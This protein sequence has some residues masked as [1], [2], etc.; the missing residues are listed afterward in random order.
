MRSA[1]S[2]T[3]LGSAA[4]DSARKA[5][6]R[7]WMIYSLCE[8]LG[9]LWK[10]F[11]SSKAVP[12]FYMS[13]CLSYL[14]AFISFVISS[15][16]LG[17][18]SGWS[19]FLKRCLLRRSILSSSFTSKLLTH[20]W[21]SDLFKRFYLSWFRNVYF[22]I[23]LNLFFAIDHLSFNSSF[24]ST[25]IILICLISVTLFLSSRELFLESWSSF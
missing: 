9:F 13:S 19:L 20:S 8:H 18:I 11:P 17:L 10:T 7:C 2:L 4:L 25:E 12:N 15:L 24:S 3:D 22:F 5:W 21:F 23:Y 1:K 16:T 6:S 14:H